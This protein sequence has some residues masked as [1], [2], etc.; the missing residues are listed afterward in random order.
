MLAGGGGGGSLIT[1]QSQIK[2]YVFK[3][4]KLISNF[5][6]TL[7]FELMLNINTTTTLKTKKCFKIVI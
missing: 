1:N 2:K 4:I 5:Y 7:Y 3:Q 6:V